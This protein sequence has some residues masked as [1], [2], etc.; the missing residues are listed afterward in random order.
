MEISSAVPRKGTWNEG[1]RYKS[2]SLDGSFRLRQ[3]VLINLLKGKEEEC[4]E[5]GVFR[6][7]S[8]CMIFK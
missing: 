3:K 5:R 4:G 7:T 6:D 1:R 2:R 8:F